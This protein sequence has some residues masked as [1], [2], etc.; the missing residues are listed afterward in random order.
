VPTR[1]ADRPTRVRAVEEWDGD[2]AALAARLADTV[3]GEVRFDAGSRGAYATDASNYRQVPIG[4]VVP[5]SVE[6]VL[7][8]VAACREL[9]APVLSRGGGTSLAGQCCN[10]A[11]VLD[12]SKH[13]NQV[14]HVDPDQRLARVQPGIVLDHLQDAVR[15]HGLLFPPDPST[16]NRCTIGGMVGNNSCGVHSVMAGK[17]VDNVRELEV[18]LYDGTR[19]RACAHDDDELDRLVD[20]GGRE[21]EIYRALRVLRDTCA[22]EVRARYPGIPRRVS[23]YNLDQLLPERGFDV[24]RALVGTEG[25]CVTVLEATVELA[26]NP[27]ARAL[28]M[29]GFPDVP[30]AADAVPTVLEHDP[31]GLEGLDALLVRNLEKKGQER[32]GRELLPPGGGWLMVEFGADEPGAA[33]AAAR[34]LIDDIG[35]DVEHRLVSDRAKQQALWEVREAGLGATAQVPGD[36]DAWPGWE[37]SAVPPERLGGYLRDLTSLFDAYGYQG[38]LYGHFGDGC[39]HVRI[40]FDLLTA[41]GV[42]DFERYMRDAADLVASYGGSLSGEHGDGQ[43][44]GEL[45]E[46]MFGSE[47]VGAF[48]RFKG[49]WDPDGRM[50]PGKVVDADGM[51][52]HLRLGADYAPWDPETVFAF[53]G[54]N[55]SLARATVRCVGVGECR[56]TTGG[57]MCPSYMATREEIHSTRGRARLLFEMLEG[58]PVSGGWRDE[59]VH[60][61][62]DLCLSCKACKRECP[63]GVDMATYKAEFLHHHWQR[64]LRP[65]PAYALG[66][67]PLWARLASR[68]PSL[69]NAL[70]R[71]PGLS[72]LGKRALGLAPDRQVPTF[73]S[74]TLRAWLEE[75]AAPSAGAPVT[76]W[77]DT[78]TNHFQPEVGRAA[79]EVLEAA[80]YRVE[81]PART[82][83]CARPLYE[84]G[85][86]PTAKRF[87]RQTLDVLEPQLRSGAPVVVLEPSCA[88]VFRD[89]LVE[90]MPGDEDAKRLARQTVTLAELLA[91]TDGYE[92]P[93]LDATVLV[94]GHCHQGAVIGYD[95]DADVLDRTGADVTWLD[96]G[97]CGM[98]GS[99][100]YEAHKYD[101]SVACAERELLP[102]VREAGADAVLLADGFSCRSQVADLAGRRALHLAELL[103]HGLRDAEGAGRTRHTDGDI[104]ADGG[105]RAAAADGRAS[106]GLRTLVGAGVAAAAAAAAVQRWRRSRR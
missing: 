77:L 66:L 8:T 53:P 84:Y 33:E 34:R 94:Q 20:R 95:A 86:L 67:I 17:T 103:Q 2:A 81:V 6:D 3:E 63:V 25:T 69:A 38:A 74:G 1:S 16:H 96:A 35:G 28:A 36:P 23:G 49:I 70:T 106:P 21:G 5:R 46:R 89:E 90:L 97:C 41:T 55:G 27:P 75:R 26:E 43:A 11:V 30:T 80:G 100:G 32:A 73:A 82:L 9:D 12:F 83:C 88:A 42:R 72:A 65:A 62:L 92:P 40:T 76:L 98:A 57:T 71:S 7:A 47:L 29:L 31:I 60:E 79:V 19:M 18:L 56:K 54:D 61:A 39:L 87:L 91:A 59:H 22:D 64:R 50:N 99:F 101:V 45:L 78:F 51:T 52:Q 104:A 68:V 37:D 10:V 93:Q 24:A 4:V 102:R 58:A 85:M 105:S 48:R 13:L 44:R 14:L 15:S